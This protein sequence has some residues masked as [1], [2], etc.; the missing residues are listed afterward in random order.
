LGL[1]EP[2]S[3]LH[4]QT[5]NCIAPKI[6]IQARDV[7]VLACDCVTFTPEISGT[8]PLAY[9]WFANGTPIQNATSPT[10]TFCPALADD[11]TVFRLEV[12][13][14]CGSARSDDIILHVIPDVT[15]PR[16]LTVTADCE[17]NK[18]TL[19]FD[20]FLA[21]KSALDPGNY[22]IDNDILIQNISFGADSNTVCVFTDPLDPA[23]TYTLSVSGVEDLCG[24]ALDPRVTATFS[25]RPPPCLRIQEQSLVCSTNS[26]TLDWTFSVHNGS[27]NA[28][29]YVLI[30]P[31]DPCVTV[32][33]SVIHFQPALGAGADV[34]VSVMLT[35]EA[36]CPA[37]LRVQFST[38]DYDFLECCSLIVDL[39][40]KPECCPN[41]LGP[42]AIEHDS[43]GLVVSWSGPGQL[44]EATQVLGPWNPV[45][46]A[47][48]PYQVPSGESQKFYRLRCP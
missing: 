42:L 16:L 39:P 44:E 4:G 9:R 38:H 45:P 29:S 32:V 2:W 20:S 1:L 24:N 3:P 46:G 6:V 40:S 31:E 11:G 7:T 28:V 23:V 26:S 17:S 10:Y 37:T 30:V 21:V 34:K 19:V 8:E 33:P 14:A 36:N 15:P 41:P 27:T 5:A 18:L 35:A 25:C 13:N 12:R 48:S 22:F 47:S 43:T